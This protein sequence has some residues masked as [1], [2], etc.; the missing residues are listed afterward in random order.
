ML[1]HLPRRTT[2]EFRLTRCP[3]RDDRGRAFRSGKKAHRPSDVGLHYEP[4]SWVF[5]LLRV[6]I[7]RAYPPL[8]LYRSAAPA[9]C[10]LTR[11]RYTVETASKCVKC[12]YLDFF[13][14]IYSVIHAKIPRIS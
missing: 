14:C 11:R 6:A 9:E 3:R 4:L 1:N 10:W 2:R 8:L 7:F 13:E 5:R 12:Y